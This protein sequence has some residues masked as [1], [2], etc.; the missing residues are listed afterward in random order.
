M[1]IYKNTMTNKCYK[2]APGKALNPPNNLFPTLKSG[3]PLYP[4]MI[5][6]AKQKEANIQFRNDKVS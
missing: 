1:Y 3:T 5:E 2:K 4:K 6:L